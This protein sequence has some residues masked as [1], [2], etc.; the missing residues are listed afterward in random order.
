MP[1]IFGIV[2]SRSSQVN[3]AELDIMLRGTAQEPLYVSGTQV[4]ETLGVAVGWTGLRNS[5]SDC[6]PLWNRNRDVCLI[7]SG[8][9]FADASVIEGLR[10]KGHEFEPG[11]AR[12]LIHLY[13]ELG[14]KFLEQL[15]GWFCGVLVDLRQ[16]EAMLFND[17]YGAR[18]VF[19][20]QAQHG[21]YFSSEAKAI[22]RVLPEVRSL[23]FKSVGEFLSCGNVLQDRT[24]FSGVSVLPAGS[25]WS[26]SPNQPVRK[27]LYFRKEIWEKLPQL[28][29]S[30]YYGRLKET[31]ARILPKYFGGKQTVGLSLTGGV[32]SRMILAWA[33]S[34]P[35][36]LPCYTWAG[37]YRDCKDVTLSRRIAEICHQPHQTIPVAEEFLAQFPFLAEK[38]IL[39]SGGGMDVTGAVDAYLQ[40]KAQQI[41][42][43][44]LTGVY[45]GEILRQLVMF[46]PVDFGGNALDPDMAKSVQETFTTYGNELQGNRLSFTAFK[47][48]PWHMA[49]KFAI[50]GSQLVYRTPYFD[51][52]LVSLAYQ[53][54]PEATANNDVSLRL[55]ADGNPA[56][57]KVETDRSLSYQAIPGLTRLM[58]AY[59][60]FT[61][62]AEYAYDYG[63]PQWLAKM[64]HAFA[65]LHLEKLFLGRHKFHHFR[66]WYRDRLSG[67]VKDMLLD[68]RTRNRPYL[69]ADALEEMVLGHTKGNRNYTLAIH[70]LLTLELVQRLL[71]ESH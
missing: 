35:G 27:K 28:T 17:R 70:K 48:V 25:V 31:W 4:E 15:N 26:F 53:S 66:V 50:E 40:H 23:D 20:H 67:Y 57:G 2:S 71:I 46:K 64:D 61:F 16:G 34:A 9:D 47:Q 51:N 44:R 60:E 41:A 39:L 36:Q 69:R 54:P 6:M 5:F 3:R 13:E 62:K 52:E 14:P 18:R 65:P 43:V 30:D 49:G 45:G 1:G 10:R 33:P 68:S 63:M 59:Q 58:H 42:P 21:L 56:L 29:P 37:S 7:F 11:N 55:I 22:L 12:Y 19:Y 8:E 32:D 38:A 24:L